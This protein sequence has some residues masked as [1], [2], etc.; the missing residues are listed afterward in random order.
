MKKADHP[1]VTV[2]I[3]LLNDPRAVR[4]VESLLKQT[5]LPDIILVADG[6]SRDGTLDKLRALGNPRV[7]IEHH[8][9]SVAETRNSALGSVT[10][11]VVAFLDADEVAPRDWLHR[12]LN[13]I[14]HDVADFAGGP[15]RPLGKPKNKTE[16]YINDFEAWFYVNIVANDITALPMGNSIWRTKIFDEIDGF[17]ERLVWGGEDYDVNLRA[18]R[19]GYRGTLVDEAWVFHDQSHLA[20]FRKVVRRKYRYSVGATVAYLK[21]GAFKDKVAPAAMTSARF[22]H[23]YEWLNLIIKPVAFFRGYAAW[24][25]LTRNLGSDF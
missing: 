10:T 21:N 9:G 15:T 24:R 1:T 2:L 8:P 18:V 5:E 11:D 7:V 20:K 4:T 3:T 14:V 12:L 16:K 23:P 6:G 13:P 17:D 25:R 19:H 22:P